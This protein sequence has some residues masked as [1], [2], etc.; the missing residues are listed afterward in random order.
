MAPAR[1]WNRAVLKNK[2][3]REKMMKTEV[4]LTQVLDARGRHKRGG[5][6]GFVHTITH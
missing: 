4:E 3:L 1:V 2:R 5:M 6:E